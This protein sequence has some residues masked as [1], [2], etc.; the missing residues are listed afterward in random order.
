MYLDF[1]EKYFDSSTAYNLFQ[2]K[3]QNIAS[4][5][6]GIC[7]IYFDIVSTWMSSERGENSEFININKIYQAREKHFY[8]ISEFMNTSIGSSEYQSCK[9]NRMP[10]LC[11]VYL[12]LKTNK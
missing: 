5:K 9:N 7:E 3:I 8:Q 12:F 10:T 6:V 1:Y 11:F 4:K 2:N